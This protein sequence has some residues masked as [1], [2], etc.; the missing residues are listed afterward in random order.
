ME[1]E[2]THRKYLKNLKPLIH[3]PPLVPL[4]LPMALSFVD[5]HS[6]FGQV[7]QQFPLAKPGALEAK[8]PNAQILGAKK[9]GHAR[10]FVG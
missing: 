6:H 7:M 8:R 3:E 4:V 2:S 5:D 1:K 9:S 10:V